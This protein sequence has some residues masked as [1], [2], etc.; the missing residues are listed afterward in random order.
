MEK[1]IQKMIPVFTICCVF[2]G[3]FST[4]VVSYPTPLS[5]TPIT[6]NNKKEIT[7]EN[8]VNHEDNH[9]KEYPALQYT[10]SF[11]E[12]DLSY[13]TLP[14]YDLVTMKT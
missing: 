10:I 6:P 3:V 14:G 2:T 4:I 8:T 11:S 12:E 13:N 1:R 9:S 7:R 5:L